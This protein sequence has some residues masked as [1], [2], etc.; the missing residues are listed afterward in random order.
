MST[1]ADEMFEAMKAK[2]AATNQMHVL[3]MLPDLTATNPIVAKVRTG[4]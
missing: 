2:L 1:S 3:E 4:L